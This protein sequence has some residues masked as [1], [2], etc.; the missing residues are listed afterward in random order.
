MSVYGVLPGGTPLRLHLIRTDGPQERQASYLT[1]MLPAG[2]PSTRIR[3][4]SSRSKRK[5]RLCRSRTAGEEVHADAVAEAELPKRIRTRDTRFILVKPA[6]GPVPGPLTVPAACPKQTSVPAKS[7]KWRNIDCNAPPSATR[8]PAHGLV[9]LSDRSTQRTFQTDRGRP[10]K[11]Q[12]QAVKS[13][14]A[15]FSWLAAAPGRECQTRRS[16]GIGSAG[17]GSSGN[18]AGRR[19]GRARRDALPIPLDQADS[20]PG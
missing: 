13:G 12:P 19:T 17:G 15:A 7:G 10:D 14:P 5:T 16:A 2:R 6:S 8:D 9:D 4:R 18:P 20:Q 1:G 3:H 11:D